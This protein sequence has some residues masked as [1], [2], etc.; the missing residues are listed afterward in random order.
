VS[1]PPLVRYWLRVLL[2]GILLGVL[3]FAGYLAMGMFG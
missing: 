2:L 3:L 1:L